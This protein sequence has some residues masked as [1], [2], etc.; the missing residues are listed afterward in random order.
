MA[1]DW[2]LPARSPRCSACGRAFEVGQI[3]QATLY[4]GA[5][6]F[7]RR[8]LC[9]GCAPAASPAPLAL[10]KT[11][12]P[13]QS[14]PRPRPFDRQAVHALFQQLEDSD[15]PPRMRL[16]FVLALLLWRKRMLR[17]LRSTWADDGCEVWHY[18]DLGGPGTYRVRRPELDEQ[19][20]MQLS[21]Q[22]E[23]LLSGRSGPAAPGLEDMIES[24][25]G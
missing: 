8:D 3:I 12:C 7:Q 17:F 5:G 9:L 22:L 20:I 19:Q 2:H 1:H 6:G 4:D 23:E 15:D 24:A 14:A 25:H 13:A 11:R 18:V 16:R 21:Q 10:W